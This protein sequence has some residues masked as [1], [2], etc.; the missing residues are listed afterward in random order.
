M[1]GGIVTAES[2]GP[3]KGSRFILS[4][5][6]MPAPAPSASA[7]MAPQAAGRRVLLVDDHEDARAMLR[8]MLEL[9]GHE[10]AEAGDGL[11]ALEAARAFRPQVAVVDIGLPRIDG[12]EVARRLRADP[13]T[14]GIALIALTGY[15]QDE[16]RQRALEAGFDE[17]LV[18]PVDEQR[19]LGAIARL[20]R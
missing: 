4:F 7:A 15:G 11:A 3:G 8:M 10:V 5:P 19:L 6:R 14:A 12:Y 20:A 13:A 2:E 18:K 16:D 1:H 17:H 9:I